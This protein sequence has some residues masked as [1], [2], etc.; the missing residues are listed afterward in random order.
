MLMK[1]ISVK[2]ENDIFYYFQLKRKGVWYNK[3]LGRSIPK[4]ISKLETNFKEEINKGV[5]DIKINLVEV[6]EKLQQEYSYLPEEELVKL[7]KEFKIPLIDLYS[8]ATFYS[9]FKL[10]KPPKYLIRVCDGTAC[11]VQGSPK[12]IEYLEKSTGLKPGQ[13]SSDNKFEIETVRCL[14]LCASAPLMTINGKVYTK[15]SLDE[16]KKIIGDLE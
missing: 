2:L 13:I 11:H 8:V 4:S 14:G 16:T 1:V 12:I 5:Y 9:Y 7:A 15:L 3:F 10:N 6:L